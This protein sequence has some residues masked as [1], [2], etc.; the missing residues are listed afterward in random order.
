MV[1]S[2]F[3]I[4]ALATPVFYLGFVD[5]ILTIFFVNLLGIIPVAFF[6][7]FGPRFGLRQMVLSRFYFG[8]TSP[9]FVTVAFL[10]ILACIG[11]SCVNTIVGAQLLNA[12]NSD[13]PGWA[14]ILVIAAAT[15]FVTLFGYKIVHAYEFW[16]WIP[17]FIIFLIVLGEF[18]RS[19]VRLSASCLPHVCLG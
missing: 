11:W 12:V 16:S 4:G 8:S 13:M 6:S 1:V 17:S 14:G 7:T 2:S 19:G 5:T 15:F 18:V 9:L 10:N 3:A